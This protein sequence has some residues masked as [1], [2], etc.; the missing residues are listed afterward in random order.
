ML[1]RILVE[2]VENL[3]PLLLVSLPFLLDLNLGPVDLCI[4]YSRVCQS[5]SSQGVVV[6][7]TTTLP[8]YFCSS[9]SFAFLK[10]PFPKN[11]RR[12]ER[13]DGCWR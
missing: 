9:H 11:P 7:E 6:N 13:G 8:P 2:F 10:W 12:A 4:G 3:L 5:Q 1:C